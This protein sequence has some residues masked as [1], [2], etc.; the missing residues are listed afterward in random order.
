MRRRGS[1]ERDERKEGGSTSGTTLVE[2]IEEL[3]GEPS[4][5]GLRVVGDLRPEGGHVGGVV[6]LAL[7]LGDA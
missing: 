5:D 7:R 3:E 1:K 2:R 6:G 4:S